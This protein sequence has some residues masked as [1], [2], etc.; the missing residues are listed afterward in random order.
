MEHSDRVGLY[1]ESFLF[2]LSCFLVPQDL[3]VFKW[4]MVPCYYFHSSF[5]VLSS[6]ILYKTILRILKQKQSL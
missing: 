2:R 4:Q 6:F 1:I 3:A 5:L